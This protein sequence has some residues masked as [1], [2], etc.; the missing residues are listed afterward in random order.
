MLCWH[1]DEV[2]WWSLK[3]C[4]NVFQCLD[5]NQG[6]EPAPAAVQ[7][8]NFNHVHFINSKFP[9]CAFSARS[10]SLLWLCKQTGGAVIGRQVTWCC[11]RRRRQRKTSRPPL[12]LVIDRLFLFTYFL[13]RTANAP[14][15]HMLTSIVRRYEVFLR[16]RLYAL[17]H[18]SAG[19][20]PL[21]RKNHI[22]E[23]WNQSIWF[24]LIHVFSYFHLFNFHST[25]FYSNLWCH[26]HYWVCSVWSYCGKLSIKK[27]G[28]IK[29]WIVRMNKLV[30]VNW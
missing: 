16:Q 27:H 5:T 23:G 9:F 24:I 15:D 3:L 22:T 6:I 1:G 19:K 8:L 30:T 28:V 21:S 29:S 4:L 10:I 7:R 18:H 25:C 12:A 20:L 17:N 11:R 26:K 2:A 14:R 13:N